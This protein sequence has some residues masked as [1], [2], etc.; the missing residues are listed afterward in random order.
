MKQNKKRFWNSETFWEYILALF[1]SV[2]TSILTTLGFHWL[3]ERL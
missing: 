1:L 3:I 2:V